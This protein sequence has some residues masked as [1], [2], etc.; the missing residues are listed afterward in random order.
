MSETNVIDQ[1]LPIT[2][3][4]TCSPSLGKLAEAL[5]KAQA[6]F[7][8]IFK[9][10]QA[11][12]YKYA[13]LAAVIDATQSALANNGLAVVQLPAVRGKDAGIET[14]LIHTS[15]EYICNELLLPVGG[16][17]FD[18]QTIGSAITY[19]RRYAY[20]SI[21]G[22]AAEFDDDGEAASQGRGSKEAAQAVAQ[23]KIAAHKAK[24][25]EPNLE[26]QLKQ[27][28]EATDSRPVI[29]NVTIGKGAAEGCVFIEYDGEVLSVWNKSLQP[30]LKDGVHAEFEVKT[31][32]SK[33]KTYNNVQRAISI[34]DVKFDDD[35]QPMLE[36][37]REV[38]LVPNPFNQIPKSE[39]PEEFLL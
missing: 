8:P 22:V 39:V 16:G 1:S 19:A 33:G 34:G 3:S 10:T 9:K 38:E 29:K 28:L 12:N 31:T 30:Y 25:S 14:R 20:Q 17:K 36:A 37:N 5:A 18:C 24:K 23:E 11:Y 26:Q 2:L 4:A 7:Q 21:V 15:G 35:N 32:K 13:D 27:S 6:E